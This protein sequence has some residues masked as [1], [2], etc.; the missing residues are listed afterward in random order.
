MVYPFQSP[1]GIARDIAHLQPSVVVAAERELGQEVQ[2]A[3]RAQ[4]ASAIVITEMEAKALPGF[5][6][7]TA[8]LPS[9]LPDEPQIE[10]LTSGTTGKPKPFAVRHAMLGEHFTGSPA[11]FGKDRTVSEPLPALLYYPLGNI[12]GLFSILPALLNGNKLIVQDRFT[13]EGWRSY[14][15]RYRPT[16]SGTPAAA[17]QMIL[18]A[19]VPKED[20]A[21]LAYFSTGAAP[22]ATEFRSFCPMAR[23]NLADRFVP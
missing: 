15:T 1:A 5:E 20:L 2:V 9:E 22:L 8:E 11:I 3:I 19:D 4:G 18:D 12:S 17:V 16:S 14:I 23:P 10:I 6:H 7:S 13:V 21:S